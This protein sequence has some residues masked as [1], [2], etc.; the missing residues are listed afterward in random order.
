VVSVEPQAGAGPVPTPGGDAT[1]DENRP[2]SERLL[3]REKREIIAAVE[4][5]NSNIA[6][7]ARVLGINRSTLYYRMRKHGLE[8]LLPTKVS[9][10]GEVPARP[11]DHA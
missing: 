5:C 8:H 7:A 10:P 4:K 6:S 9:V 11:S 3:D 1:G 2:L